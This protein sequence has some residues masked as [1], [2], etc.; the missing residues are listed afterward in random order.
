MHNIKSYI[1]SIFLTTAIFVISCDKVNHPS[2]G[3]YPKD[4]S[5]PTGP[6]NFYAAYDGILADSIRATFPNVD[7]STTFV[8]GI[9]GQA[10]Q[11]NPTLAGNGTDQTFS[12]LVYPS[13]NNWSSATSFTVNFWL[14]CPLAKKDNVNADGV[15]TWASTSNFWGE[16][17]WYADHTTGGPSDSMD[18]KVHFANGSGDNWDFAGYT[19]ANRWPHM[20]DGNWHMVTFVY[21]ASTLTATLYEDG[22]QFDHKTNETIAWDG[23]GSNLIVAGFEQANN[24]QGNYAGNTWM[25]S[26]PGAVD[27]V[28]LYSVAL[29]ASDVAA[30]YAGKE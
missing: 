10:V 14:M 17:T 12:Y 1:A 4:A 5:S 23:N 9:S 8:Q 27:H 2:L 26:W 24:I 7:S 29:Q 21:D 18:L 30:L 28:R 25:N 11:F 15:L 20:Y 3:T 16:M 22:N 13:P 19:G 6:L